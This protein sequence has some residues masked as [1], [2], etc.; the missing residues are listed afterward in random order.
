MQAGAGVSKRIKAGQAITAA[1]ACGIAEHGQVK[2]RC[3]KV[4]LEG[5][6]KIEVL[7]SQFI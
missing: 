7:I 3:N 4:V 2:P 6:S 5:E 1:S